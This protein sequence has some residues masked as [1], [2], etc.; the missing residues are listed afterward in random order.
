MPL[1]A[2][3]TVVK[4]ISFP[5]LPTLRGKQRA[6]A[7]QI[8]VFSTENLEVDADKIGLKGSP[9]RV[10]KIESPKVTR[11]GTILKPSDERSMESAVDQM[12]DFFRVKE[13]I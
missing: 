11:N 6:R 10:I 3:L 12:I 4:E 5:R 8:P 2:L 1:P 7:A 13:I 9:T